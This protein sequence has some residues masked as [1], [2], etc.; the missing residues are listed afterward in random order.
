MLARKQVPGLR[1]SP[2]RA[3][4]PRPPGSPANCAARRGSSGRGQLS[5]SV[6]PLFT[7]SLLVAAQT[8]SPAPFCSPSTGGFHP[9]PAGLEGSRRGRRLL[10]ISAR[11]ASALPGACPEMRQ[12][13]GAAPSPENA[14]CASADEGAAVSSWGARYLC[15]GRQP[16]ISGGAPRDQ[17]WLLCLSKA[18]RTFS[19]PC[20]A[21][22]FNDGWAWAACSFSHLSVLLHT[23]CEALVRRR[24]N[25]PG[26]REPFIIWGE[27]ERG[28]WGNRERF[29]A[30]FDCYKR[31]FCSSENTGWFQ[32][33]WFSILDEMLSEQP[34]SP[35]QTQSICSDAGGSQSR[36]HRSLGRSKHSHSF[37]ASSLQTAIPT[38]TSSREAGGAAPSV[39]LPP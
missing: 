25:A 22:P 24:A 3:V 26:L 6:G 21:V 35:L 31:S 39:P 36:G 34:L 27:G 14:C 18:R 8:L 5:P 38:P 4:E 33:S 30:R 15:G 1:V 23:S 17:T 16:C 7:P 2:G 19:L 11:R 9:G 10:Q 32:L 13:R 20:P 12:G 29:F 28:A 37:L